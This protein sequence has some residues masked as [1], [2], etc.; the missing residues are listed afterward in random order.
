M[1]GQRYGKCTV[2]SAQICYE[3]NTALKNKVY[4]KK[5]QEAFVLSSPAL[6]W[7]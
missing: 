5:Q 6:N 7:A 4:E 3:P 1:W 2:P